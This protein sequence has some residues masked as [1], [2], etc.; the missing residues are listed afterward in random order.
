M[1]EKLKVGVWVEDGVVL[2]RES[3]KCPSVRTYTPKK[4][5]LLEDVLL[6]V[7]NIQFCTEMT[8]WTAT[9]EYIVDREVEKLRK[10]E[11][12]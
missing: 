11:D 7:R 9:T 4:P 2:R 1:E 12:F 8:N 5:E 3:Q 10:I 6:I